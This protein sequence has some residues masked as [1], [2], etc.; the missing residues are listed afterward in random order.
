MGF[1]G[2]GGGFCCDE[3]FDF[4]YFFNELFLRFIIYNEKL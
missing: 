3:I 4:Y 2:F 1:L